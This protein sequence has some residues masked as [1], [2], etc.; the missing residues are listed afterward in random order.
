MKIAYCVRP[1]FEDGGDGVQ[2]LKTK[3]NIEAI[4]PNVKIQILTRPEDLNENYDLVHI[5]NYATPDLTLS[6]FKEAER[7]NLKIVSSPVYWDYS[8][9]IMPLYM[10][11]WCNKSF[12]SEKFVKFQQGLQPLLSLLPKFLIKDAYTNVSNKFGKQ[13]KYFIEKSELILPNSYQEGELCCEFAKVPEAKIKIREIYNG[14]DIQ[15]VRILSEN[16][17]FDKYNIP[18][19]YILQVG[20]IEYLKNQMN[21]ISSL[22]DRP[23]IPIVFLGN[24]KEWRPYVKQVRKIA[25]KRGNVFFITGVPHDEVYS[26]YK[27]AK[28]HVLLSMRESPGL[29]SLE[30]LSQGC[31]IVISDERCLPINTYFTNNYI[32]VN[33]FDKE[34]IKASILK[35]YE[36][37]HIEID[38][39]KFSWQNVA[40]QTMTA[41]KEII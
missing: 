17:F 35:A 21:L 37:P 24:G 6:F 10:Y 28:V 26:F 5:F 1:H 14:V 8:L 38:L 34:A 32:S 20:R 22:E 16:E 33:P 25:A 31:P 15:D 30:A 36:M 9:S 7:L 39:S 29:V 41:Y 2:V 19:N 23:D 12:I 3:E 27:Y 18:H 13:I 40:K 4:E 11:F